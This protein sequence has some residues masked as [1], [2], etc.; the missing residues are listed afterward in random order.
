MERQYFVD[1]KVVIYKPRRET[2]ERITP[3]HTLASNFR[4]PES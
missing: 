2:L 1:W 3:A 4:P